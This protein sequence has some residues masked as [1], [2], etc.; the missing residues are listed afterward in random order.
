MKQ[1]ILPSILAFALLSLVLLMAACSGG[2]QPRSYVA[3]LTSDD[4][5][6][7]RLGQ[8]DLTRYHSDKLGLDINYPSF[9]YHQDLPE[10]PGQELFM[11]EDI[12]ISVVVDSLKGMTRSA[13]QQ[14]MNMGADLVESGDDY[15][16]QEG[17][18]Q[19]WDYYGKVMDDDT[20]RV[21]TIMLRYAPH[22]S[23]A[24]APLRDWVRDFS[25]K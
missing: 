7:I 18:E 22:H 3:E 11:Y 20:L 19:D 1:R 14:M 25:L 2:Q 4:S 8:W 12:S 16:I 9:L 13:S 5:M 24:V 17:S 15:S 23:E 10:E 6:T 21:V